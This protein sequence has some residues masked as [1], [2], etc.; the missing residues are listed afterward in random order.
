MPTLSRDVVLVVKHQT[1]VSVW[2]M[3]DKSAHLDD[4]VVSSRLMRFV[5]LRVLEQHFVHVGRRVLE[6]LVGATE[7][8]QGNLTIAQHRQLVGLLHQAELALGERH[9][10]FRQPQGADAKINGKYQLNETCKSHRHTHTQL[11]LPKC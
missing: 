3:Q 9:L 10:P 2:E 5:I 6:Q 1:V 7:D 4:V 8:D 11:I